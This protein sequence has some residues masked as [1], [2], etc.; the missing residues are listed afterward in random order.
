MQIIRYVALLCISMLL[1]AC[2]SYNGQSSVHLAKDAKWGI[3][4][5]I[6]YS[7]APQAG[8]RAEQILQSALAA[9]GINAPRYHAPAQADALIIDEAERLQSGLTWAREQGFT[10]VFSGSVEE[11]QYK[12]GLDGEPAVGVTLQV[13]EVASNR[14]VWQSSGARAG[15]SRESIAGAAQK[16]IDKLI[17]SLKF[18]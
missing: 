10:Y 5:I 16:V 6:N 17:N 11:W 12:S 8:E 4:P 9:R 18:D 2:S 7:Q 14:I 1:T 13:I 3:A 15:W